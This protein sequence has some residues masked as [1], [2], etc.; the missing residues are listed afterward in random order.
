MED[1]AISMSLESTEAIFKAMASWV[2]LGVEIFACAIIVVAI[3]EAIVISFTLKFDPLR[4]LWKR[5]QIFLRFGS[6]LILA[7]EF[8]LAADIVR[9]AI[10][11]SWNQIGMLAAIAVIRT[12][13]NFF[14][15]RDVEK[16]SDSE[17]G[18]VAEREAVIRE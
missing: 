9:S 2:A 12:F 18:F 17:R 14:L 6:W 13:L 11:P 7:L 3:I 5:K 15:E 16:F 8:E 4:P 10:A 1:K